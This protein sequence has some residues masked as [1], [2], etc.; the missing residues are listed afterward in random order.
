MK[1]AMLEALKSLTG[2]KSTQ[3]SAEELE[4]LIA[5]AREERA[6]IAEMLMSLQTRSA[7]LV[8]MSKSLEQMTEKATTATA[9]LDEI[10]RRLATLDERTR[11]LED[12]DK[13]IQ[14]LK[15]A[16]RQAEQTTE[17]AIGPDGELRKHREAVQQLSS[18]AL[19]TQATLDTLKKER[20]ALDELRTKLR[21]S[22]NEVKHAMGQA[23]TLKGDLEQIRSTAASLT[24]DYGKLRDT[25]REAREYSTAAMAVAK[26]IETKLEPLT[27]V[28]ELSESTAERLASLNALSEHVSRKAKAIE[29]QQQ[30]VEH[31]VVQANRVSE[32]V[33]SMDAQIAK[34]NEGMKQVAKAEETVGRIEKLS[35]ETT[36][37]MESSSKLNEDVQREVA[38]QQKDSTALLEAVR[39][40]VGTLAIRKRE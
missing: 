40:E 36:A 16:A 4:R 30:A 6:A 20:A 23:G 10:A 34:L 3:K 32:M 26:E 7:K 39:T 9:R 24:Q 15:E 11:E 22:E 21:A 1:P 37:R 12:V 14:A 38:K 27:Q 13:R 33:W 17:K 25:S 8:P 29:S 28:H 35:D 18:Q 31:A 19:Q 5:T 2:G